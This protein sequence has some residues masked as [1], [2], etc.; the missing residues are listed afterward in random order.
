[1][2][3]LH[4]CGQHLSYENSL[5]IVL[6]AEPRLYFSSNFRALKRLQLPAFLRKTRPSSF[7]F[8][9]PS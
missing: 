4:V 1:M 6:A 3:C 7:H 5:T 9:S 2:N 8:Y